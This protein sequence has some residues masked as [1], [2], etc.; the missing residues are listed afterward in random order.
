MILLLSIALLPL[1]VVGIFY[2]IS[3]RVTA[4]KVTAD[5]RNV[6]GWHAHAS[7]EQVLQD[8]EEKLRIQSNLLESLVEIQ[9]LAVNDRLASSPRP[10]DLE[11]GNELF[12]YSPALVPPKSF[13]HSYLIFG[14]SPTPDTLAVDFTRQ[15]LYLSVGTSPG[16]AARDAARLEKLTPVYYRLYFRDP[17]VILWHYTALET[18]IIATFPGG[19]TLPESYD[20]RK[21][22][23]YQGAKKTGGIFWTF[24]YVDASTRELL[25]TVSAPVYRPN[26]KFAGVTA[27]DVIVP[28]I[29]HLSQLDPNWASGAEAVLISTENRHPSDSLLVYAR[30]HFQGDNS[31]WATSLGTEY[32]TSSDK[33]QFANLVLDMREGRRGIRKMKYRGEDALWVYRGFS[34]KQ[35]Y[36]ILIVPYRNVIA[37]AQ[38]TEQTILTK[39]TQWFSFSVA[40]VLLVAI[41]AIFIAIKRSQSFTE[42]IQRLTRVSRKLAGGNFNVRV[43]IHTGDELQEL[44][45]VFNEIGPR[46]RERE[47]MKYSLEAARAIQQRLLPSEDPQVV[48]FDISGICHYSDETGGDYYDF[49]PVNEKE[50]A[51]LI[52]ALG[53]VSGHGIGAALL[54]ATA[55]TVLRSSVRQFSGDLSRVLAETNNLLA[56]DTAPEKFITLFC[57][58]LDPHSREC[59]WASGGHDPAIWYRKQTGQVSELIGEGIP[60]GFLKA[61][62]FPQSQPIRLEKGD[63]VVIGTDGIWE[64]ENENEEMFGKERLQKLVIENAE[65][66]AR[67]I[68]ETV[69][70]AVKQFCGRVPQQ[71]DITIVVLKAI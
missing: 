28:Q 61:M 49:I 7:M 14:N 52:I 19:N 29:F 8:F 9:Q 64:A 41:I 25:I 58:A 68:G 45:E 12:G 70:E 40:F 22:P 36:P 71:D 18:G 63:I 26:G 57:L 44:G 39:N 16:Q 27:I 4:Q 60:L 38:K 55:R 11:F 2:Q 24:P 15:S 66:S 30:A 62:K 51:K 21:R 13:P 32:L 65:K 33:E 17:D 34:D 59:T 6:L 31:N 5:M 56:A 43:K 46:L 23:W 1:I 42:P 37:L 35:V 54:M 67:E 48:N 10:V 47:Q 69:I 50:P 20:P 53:D 3:F